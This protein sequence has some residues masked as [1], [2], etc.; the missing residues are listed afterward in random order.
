MAPSQAA[1]NMAISISLPL[2][3]L[4]ESFYPFV[5]TFSHTTRDTCLSPFVCTEEQEPKGL[6]RSSRASDKLIY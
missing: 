2:L 4:G 5:C 6:T 3:T 1:T